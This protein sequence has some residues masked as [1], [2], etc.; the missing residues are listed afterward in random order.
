MKCAYVTLLST[1][2]Y[3][4]GVVA[5]FE[6]LKLTKPKYHDFVVIINETINRD[7]IN[8]LEKRGYL[9]IKKDKIDFSS[10]VSN[11]SFTYWINTFDKLHIFELTEYDKIIYLDSD[12]FI[13]KNIDD[14][15]DMPHLSGAI[16]GKE[17]YNEWDGI[18]SG[19]M[20]I[21]PEEGILT[22]LLNVISTHKFDKDIGDQDIINYYYDWPNKNLAI[23]EKYN[24][25]YNLIDYYIEKLKYNPNDVRCIHYIGSRK[26]WMY[27]KKEINS[28]IFELIKENK[29]YELFY[30]RKYLEILE[31]A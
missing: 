5:M 26:P 24:I 19:L 28:K 8:K 6:S 10:I 23:S 31:K 9:V 11:N 20:V 12:L 18:N 21:V 29:K 2:E 3:Y 4:P 7:I 25:F 16:S 17:C 1:N 15:F 30:F 27:S 14:L 13:V 22:K